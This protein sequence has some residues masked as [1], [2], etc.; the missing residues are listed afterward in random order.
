LSGHIILAVLTGAVMNI[1]IGFLVSL[2]LPK[3]LGRK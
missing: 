3:V 2:L 1:V